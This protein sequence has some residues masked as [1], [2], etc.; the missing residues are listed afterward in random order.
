MTALQGTVAAGYEAV[1]DEFAAIAAAEGE[2]YSA[3]LVAH[4]RGDRVVDLWTGP[5]I[6][7][8]S[9]TGVFSATKGAAHLVVALLVQDGVLD[10][11][12][13]VAD[14]WPEFGIEGKHELTLRDLISHR[15]GV[16][17]A[18]D[19]FRIDEIADDRIIAERLA[20]QRPYWRPGTAFGYHALVIG[21]L[22]GEVV[23][24]VTGQSIQEIH[25][26]R[27]RGPLGIDFYLGLPAE[28]EPRWLS[29]QPMRPTP[30][31]L[32]Q[33]Q[34][35]ATGP[36]SITGIAFNRNHPEAVDL[37]EL[38][39]HRVVRELGPASVGGVGTARGLADFY[40]AITTG[41]HGH[42]PLLKPD[43]IAA[44][45]QIHSAGT[46]LVTRQPSA[47][48]LGFMSVGRAYPMLGQGAFGHAGATGTE[49]F[50]DPRN[51]IAYGYVR[52]RFGF[53]GGPG[54]E[55]LGLVRALHAAATTA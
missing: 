22:T 48:G 5:D 43:L 31:Q 23:R 24:R 54:P 34:A 10:L 50:A 11:D 33:L 8:D 26:A 7:A 42:A 55:N 37:Q 19:G 46:D 14:Y 49:A 38:P 1:R 52:R 41:L 16:V 40:A 51:G 21:A 47:F 35:A 53:P 29:T 39:N 13:P 9:L 15:A 18:D 4:V 36:N 20:G 28:L 32:T 2:D 30:E 27:V 45:G 3:Q 6:T 25:E 12:R 44:V 17:G